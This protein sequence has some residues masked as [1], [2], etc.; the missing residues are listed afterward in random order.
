[1]SRGPTRR[2]NGEGTIYQRK[3]GRWEGAAYVLTTA[4]RR[5]RK[6]VYGATRE[7]AHA[8]ITALIGDSQRG[9]A[10]AATA[11][12]VGDYL[13]YWLQE[14]ARPKVRAST[15]RSY[16]TYVRIYLI[17]GLGTKRLDR[18]T[19]R[20]IRTWLNSVR[21]TC[22]C[23]AQDHDRARPE[24]KRRC[25][26]VGDCCAKFP[27]ARTI[28]Y[29]HAL[30]RAALAHAVR[31]DLLP[32]NVARQVQVPAGERPEIDPLTVEEAKK[33]LAAARA[34][35]LH[36]IYAVALGV[37]LRRGEALGLRWEDVDLDPGVL[38]VRQTVQRAG[39]KLV[40][41]P[42]KTQRS[43]RAI[44]LLP[45]LVSALTE[46]RDRQDRERAAAGQRWQEHGLVFTTTIGTPIEPRNLNRSFTALCDS[47][48]IRRIR[49]HDLRHTCAT[50]L[51]AQGV[52]LRMIMEI[53]GHSAIAVT[54]NL[55]THVKLDTQR[56][57][58]DKL[59]GLF[60]SDGAVAVNAAVNGVSTVASVG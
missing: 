57:A 19:A 1:M 36:A 24:A 22:Q 52:D 33:L 34:D 25:C 16:E 45:Q 28:A 31:E 43:R 20:D 8:K 44:P 54:G 30:I 4:G 58:L 51:L 38:R 35:R 47:A 2:A 60:G 17:P 42:P 53:L 5:V 7:Q 18:L 14:V 32:R 37:G 12:N 41:V 11:Q 48:G 55:Y 39:G 27:S 29:L 56:S 26:A 23:C 49:L 13:G 10:V 6:R 46:H 59:T 40:F 50:L 21:T 3:D 9:I 15:F